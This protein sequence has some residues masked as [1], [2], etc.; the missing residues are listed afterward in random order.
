MKSQQKQEF[1][2]LPKNTSAVL[3]ILL[4]VA[5]GVGAIVWLAGKVGGGQ[6]NQSANQLFTDE[7]SQS[8]QSTHPSSTLDRRSIENSLQTVTTRNITGNVATGNGKPAK[9]L[10]QGK[11][12]E[13]VPAITKA[14]IGERLSLLKARL[15]SLQ[16]AYAQQDVT[17]AQANT[18]LDLIKNNLVA[19]MQSGDK[20]ESAPLIKTLQ[21]QIIQNQN[22]ENQIQQ[23]RAAD[24]TTLRA[25]GVRL[26]T[27][28]ILLI[29]WQDMQLA[30]GAA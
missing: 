5:I 15:E 10:E 2:F 12:V 21:S 8:P 3:S 27:L 4:I 6:K 28:Q 29:R 16:I 17:L 11:P 13:P 1:S 23:G 30:Q 25:I 24:M 26:G 20:Q 19:L 7:Q 22:I 14:Q 9:A 18:Q